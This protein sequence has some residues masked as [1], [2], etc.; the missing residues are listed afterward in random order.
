MI[1]AVDW[2]F[3]TGSVIVAAAAIGAVVVAAAMA[4]RRSGWRR[5]VVM[6]EAA[7]VGLV[8]VVAVMLLGPSWVRVVGRQRRP[9]AV[10]LVDDTGSMTTRDVVVDG[11]AVSRREAVAGWTDGAAFG[12]GDE[13]G[14]GDGREVEVVVSMVGEADGGG[15]DLG[16]AIRTAAETI[17]EEGRELVAVALVGDGDWNA[18]DPPSEAALRLKAAGVGVVAVPVGGATPPADVRVASVDAPSFAV[19]GKALRV[20]VAIES[21]LPRPHDAVVT[22]TASSGA[23]VSETM[24]LRPM[25]TTRAALTLPSM[26]AGET[27]VRVEVAGHADEIRGDN[28]SA[29]AAVSV[30]EERLK[31]LV[32]ESEPRWEYR[33]LRNALSRDPGVE[34]SCLLFHPGADSRGGGNADYVAGFPATKEW[35]SKFD[36]CFLGDVGIGPG[37]LSARQAEWLDGWVRR[38]AGGLVLVPGRR[39]RQASFAGTPLGDISPVDVDPSRPGGW[40]SRTPG[41]FDLTSAG[42]SSLLTKLADDPAENAAVWAGLPGFSW[43][44]AV[45][46]TRPGC[47]TLAVHADAVGPRGRL[48]LLATRAAGGG[49]VLFLGTDAAWRWRRGVE[50]KYHYRFWGQVVRWMAYRRN[51]AEGES[52]RLYFTPERPRVGRSVAVT[53]NVMG[54]D[55]GPVSGGD[56]TLRVVAPEGGDAGGGGVSAV[57]LRGDGDDWGAY[58][59]TVVPSVAGEHRLTLLCDQTGET[60]EA[61]LPVA[62]VA[63]EPVDRVARPEVLEEL[64]RMTGG[65][66]LPVDRPDRLATVLASR[67]VPPP[68]VR[69]RTLWDHPLVMIVLTGGLTTFW[70]ARK[71][72]GLF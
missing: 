22:L 21:T 36:V 26:P 55:G 60:L 46:A 62:G 25:G 23:T 14:G 52:M 38:Q 34:V 61:T 72:A 49:K 20:P 28:N 3:G 45:V 67:K 51:I 11:R 42:R 48:P 33:F 10:V 39:G 4:V 2:E 12:V 64:A 68:E 56:V 44:A 69:R 17:R 63:A 6:L 57:R 29:E 58:V 1:A 35:L 31:V 15:T 7:R 43:W 71:A 70:A 40:G 37:G 50:D 65:E 41:H 27:M 8:L 54:V 66:V 47:E 19:A 5:S 18:G 24:R 30:R 53:A 9:V 59:G 13:G 16:A 32:V